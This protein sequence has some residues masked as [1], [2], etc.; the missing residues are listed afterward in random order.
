MPKLTDI[1]IAINFWGIRNSVRTIIYTLYRDWLNRKYSRKKSL[2]YPENSGKYVG[3]NLLPNGACEVQYVNFVL[4]L[5]F[6]APSLVRIRWYRRS[7]GW[8][9]PVSYALAKS[10]WSP[11]ETQH[12][13]TPDGALFRSPEIQ[14]LIKNDGVLTFLDSAGT[15]VRQEI[16]PQYT[17][18]GWI[19][20]SPLAPEERIYGLGEQADG[21]NLRGS[22]H[23]LFNTDANGSYGPNT[24]PLYFPIPVFMGIHKQGEY[25]L[26]HEN[27]HPGMITIDPYAPAGAEADNQGD[28]RNDAF[29]QVE[30]ESPA[31]QYYFLRGAPKRLLELYTELTG[32][33]PLPPLW[34]LGY[35]QSRWG[36]LSESDIREVVAGFELHQMPISAIHLD[37]DYMDGYR[38]FTV[39]QEQF[40]DL[41]RLSADLIEANI[42]LVAILDPGVKMDPDYQVYQEG[43]RDG[44]FCSLPNGGP[45]RGLVWPGWSVYPDFTNPRTRQWW[46]S[47]YNILQSLG[48]SGFWH[49]MN[50]PTSFSSWGGLYLPEE[51]QHNL[52]GRSGDHREAHNVYALQMNRA[53]FEALDQSNLAKRPWLLSRSGWAGNQRYTW[54]WTGDT[55]SSW[56]SLKMTIA[57]IIGLGLSGIPFTGSDIGGFSGDPSPELYLRWF[58]TATFMPFFRT[59]SALTTPRREPWVFGEPFTSI[60]RNFLQLR[61]CL[62]PY[63]YTLAWE[64]S[65]SGTP[66]IR[67]LF[68][69]HPE[70]SELLDVQ[71][72]FLLGDALLVAPIMEP[73]SDRREVVFPP[74]QWTS[75]WDE[76]DTIT[77]PVRLPVSANLQT[78]PVYVRSGSV[79]PLEKDG[80]LV[81]HV[82]PNTLSSKKDVQYKGY[83]QLYSDQGDGNGPCRLDQFHL[84]QVA[85]T[86]TI[87]WRISSDLNKNNFPFPYENIIIQVH[88]SLPKKIWIDGSLT[89][90]TGSQIETKPFKWLRIQLKNEKR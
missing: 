64:S 38:V 8:H 72:T 36:Y 27:T 89:T 43:L 42:H 81:L 59:H 31:I 46:G 45:V 76:A 66:L 53:G 73:A 35:H 5:R 68:W 51:T 29:L 12:K 34:S 58:Q 88:G 69:N 61:Y 32:R 19:L 75:F 74:G 16:S 30:F 21:L 26:F 55:E 37:I 22:S 7:I 54:N 84:S 60:I 44:L 77:G 79:V 80:M 1:F 82:F 33:S 85:D 3:T 13:T 25:L 20:Q 14:I 49:D 15:I 17:G 24:D 86:L 9:P 39:N 62:L 4:E 83:G 23:R 10:E 71:D 2:S 65:Q 67:P 11:V 90:Q 70:V 48:I 47:K 6:L 41:G 50:E 63:L 87:E 40:P 18:R 56:S 52:D 28:A 78:I 57:T